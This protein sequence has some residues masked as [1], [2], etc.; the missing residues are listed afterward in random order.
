M[1]QAVRYFTVSRRDAA[2]RLGVHPMTIYR[3]VKNGKIEAQRSMSGQLWFDPD[4]IERL[5]HRVG[6]VQVV[7]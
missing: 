7:E 5:K 4:E 1:S 3:W 6:G 2:R